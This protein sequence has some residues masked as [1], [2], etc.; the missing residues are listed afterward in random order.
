MRTEGVA[1]GQRGEEDLG[2]G[3]GGVIACIMQY[4]LLYCNLLLKPSLHK[5]LSHEKTIWWLSLAGA[6]EPPKVAKER[7]L[8][9]AIEIQ[10]VV[11]MTSIFGKRELN[12]TFGGGI[13]C[14]YNA[15]YITNLYSDCLRR[16]MCSCL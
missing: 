3:G 13:Q 1:A 4:I 5:I 6:H 15:N 11:A 2:R 14:T 12:K 10:I 8:A 9:S 16:L 7:I